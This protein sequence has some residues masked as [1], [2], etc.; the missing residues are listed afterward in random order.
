MI[1]LNVLSGKTAGTS[2]VARRFPVRI[3]RAASSE[4]RLDEEGVWER[5]V[6]LDFQPADGFW[7]KTQPSALA[8]VNGRLVEQ[9]LL[10][11]GDT[12]EMGAVRI[13]FWLGRARQAGLA[14]GEALSW[15]VILALSL[16]QVAML[17]W[18]LDLT[19]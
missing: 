18:L 8:R 9:T 19:N 4:L 2:W 17:Y 6:V 1:Q 3:G 7:L 12:I 14:L 10:R 13:Q 15:G 16:V 5:H 11:N